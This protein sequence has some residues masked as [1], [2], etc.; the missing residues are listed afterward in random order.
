MA[1]YFHHYSQ[2]SFK[3]FLINFLSR[4]GMKVLLAI[5]L[6]L[7]LIFL[8]CVGS[9]KEQISIQQA[10]QNQQPT[11]NTLPAPTKTYKC[12]NGD[13]VANLS[14]CSICPPSCDDNNYC[15]IDFCNS[16]TNYKCNHTVVDDLDCGAGGTCKNGVCKE[17]EPNLALINTSFPSNASNGTVLQDRSNET[18]LNE[19]QVMCI[20]NDSMCESSCKT[21]LSICL[22]TCGCQDFCEGSTWDTLPVCVQ[23]CSKPDCPHDCVQKFDDSA[24][25][26]TK[27]DRWV[28]DGVCPSN[29][30]ARTDLDCPVYESRAYAYSKNKKIMLY[31]SGTCLGS[32]TKVGYTLYNLG[33]SDL[34]IS[35]A[36]FN[37]FFENYEN[38]HV[39][40]KTFLSA[41]PL[42]KHLE[43]ELDFSGCPPDGRFVFDSTDSS[44]DEIVIKIGS[45]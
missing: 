34:T 2:K 4:D 45:R 43:G 18:E 26:I 21:K 32:D 42:G 38:R 25:C 30:S 11:Q 19:S 6:G 39:S 31:A 12:P 10:S 8:G 37:F 35:N 13:V 14:V 29:C 16:K 3:L 40:T 5:G 36:N 17:N 1:G 44:E 33:Y 9:Q 7:M 24:D 22:Q 20:L 23:K 28:K 15:T 27:C 41:L